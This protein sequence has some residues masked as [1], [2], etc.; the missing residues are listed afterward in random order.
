M[1]LDIVAQRFKNSGGSNTPQRFDELRRL[2]QGKTPC[3]GSLRQLFRNQMQRSLADEQIPKE[4]VS[5]Y[6]PFLK[7]LLHRRL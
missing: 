2:V 4:A 3:L 5:R 6:L 1:P 7:S